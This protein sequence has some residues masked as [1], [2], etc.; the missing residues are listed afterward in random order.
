M[1]S[2]EP[3]CVNGGGKPGG[4]AEISSTVHH[5]LISTGLPVTPLAFKGQETNFEPWIRNTDVRGRI[6]AKEMV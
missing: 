6:R 1:H 2:N 5:S 4:D 3:A